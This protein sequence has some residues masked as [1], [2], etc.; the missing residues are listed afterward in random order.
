M[1]ETNEG[2]SK[3]QLEEIFENG[4]KMCKEALDD[5][6]VSLRLIK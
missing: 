4:E 5:H 1:N 3:S 6:Y 2:L